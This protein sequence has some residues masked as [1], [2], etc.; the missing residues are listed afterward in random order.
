M[1]VRF[2]SSKNIGVHAKKSTTGIKRERR[3]EE[4]DTRE[5]ERE[6]FNGSC[7]LLPFLHEKRRR[8]FVRI[9]MGKEVGV[10][11]LNRA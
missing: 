5:R 3:K 1:R 9:D 6:M 10:V 8:S 2:S 11:C 7:L 4:R